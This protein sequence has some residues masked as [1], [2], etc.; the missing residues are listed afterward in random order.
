[1]FRNKETCPESDNLQYKKRYYTPGMHEQQYDR[2]EGDEMGIEN[3]LSQMC[4]MIE[5]G[6]LCYEDA[7]Y[8]LNLMRKKYGIWE[9]EFRQIYDVWSQ[10]G[11]LSGKLDQLGDR[12]KKESDESY[13]RVLEGL[14]EMVE[15]GEM[16]L[17]MVAE[18]LWEDA[19]EI[20]K[21]PCR[22]YVGFYPE[23]PGCIGYGKD[24]KILRE[25]MKES[26]EKW[27][28]A[29]YEQWRERWIMNGC[30]EL[31]GLF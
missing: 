29:G 7:V 14:Y 18:N 9:K 22:G 10:K 12:I 19:Y 1:M 20:K 3:E 6:K 11:E 13:Q 16:T 4:A 26:L 15:M 2:T 8:Y 28:R 25:N 23:L 27:I 24:R 31:E 21:D 30:E 5:S 17:E